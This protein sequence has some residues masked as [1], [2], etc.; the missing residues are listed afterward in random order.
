[1]TVQ[2]TREHILETLSERAFINGLPAEWT[3]HPN[4]HDYGI[5]LKVEI[6]D[7]IPGG[8]FS[9]SGHEFAVQLKATDDE[10]PRRMRIGV[11][12]PHVQYWERLSYPTLLARYCASTAKTYAKWTHQ[13]GRNASSVLRKQA[14]YYFDDADEVTASR[15]AQIQRDV[16]SFRTARTGRIRLPLQ[17]RLEGSKVTPSFELR[18]NMFMANA[19]GPNSIVV[20]RSIPSELRIVIEDSAYAVDLGGGITTSVP[21]DR[22]PRGRA[23]DLLVI[24]QPVDL[25]RLVGLCLGQARAYHDAAR[26]LAASKDSTLGLSGRF[27]AAAVSH[28][29][30][31]NDFDT[32]VGFLEL[33]DRGDPYQH[34]LRTQLMSLARTIGPADL[35]RLEQLFHDDVTAAST[36]EDIGI[37]LF[38]RASFYRVLNRQI[39]AMLDYREA[40]ESWPQYETRTDYWRFR[41]GSEF[42]SGEFSDS[43]VSYGRAIK[44]GDSDPFLRE[45]MSDALLEAGQYEAVLE[46]QQSATDQTGE[47][48]LIALMAEGVVDRF[49]IRQQ[50]RDPERALQQLTGADWSEENNIATAQFDAL[51]PDIWWVPLESMRERENEGPNPL[52]LL[53]GARLVDSDPALWA[54]ALA[55]GALIGVEGGLVVESAIVRARMKTGAQFDSE[56]LKHVEFLLNDASGDDESRVRLEQL[57]SLTADSSTKPARRSFR[58]TDSMSGVTTIELV[59]GP[60]A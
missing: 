57:I 60:N 2:R 37:A 20:G 41:A 42:L 34:A 47:E 17:I 52:F 35:A 24:P 53:I 9:P 44:C 45:L 50:K 27:L 5:D 48:C 51:L 21:I 10:T 15:W 56:L 6:F 55:Y 39:E 31:A 19:L 1:M 4:R 3:D 59:E 46:V 22:P 29:V 43:A 8:D 58:V 26:C 13:W 7:E 25:L 49:G 33:A 11:D 18:T 14:W 54:L 38:N 30:A 23:K 28:C 12:W 32:A 40:A 16:E 36:V